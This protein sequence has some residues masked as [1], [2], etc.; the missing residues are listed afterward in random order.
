M[1][2]K[3][4]KPK[5]ILKNAGIINKAK[6]IKNLKFSSNVK[7]IEIQYKFVKKYPNPNSHP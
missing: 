6:G 1:K 2:K 7:E 4:I 5:N 3:N